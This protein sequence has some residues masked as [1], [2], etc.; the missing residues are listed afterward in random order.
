MINLKNVDFTY[1]NA[2]TNIGVHHVNLEISKGQVVLLCGSSGCG[3]TTLTRMINGLIP[4]FYEGKLSGDI[5]VCGL[6]VKKSELYELTPF[7]GSVFQNPKSQFYTVQ[8]DSEIVFGCENIGLKK[9][10]IYQRFEDVVGKLNISPL[11]G[12]SLFSLSGGQ[13]QKIACAS[14]ATLFPEIFVMDEPSSNLDIETIYELAEIIRE[15][16]KEKKTVVIAEHRLYWLMDIADRVIYIKDGKILQDI[17]I[18]EFKKISIDTLSKMGLR[19]RKISFDNIQFP[20]IKSRDYIYFKDFSFS[21]E[22]EKNVNIKSLMIPCGSVV[23]IIGKN[24]AG[25]STFGRCMCG[26]EKKTKG[27]MI[28]YGKELKWKERIKN[29]Y[30]VMQDVNHQLFTESV[31]D[32]I[33]LSMENS[34]DNESL[35]KV[36]AIEIL[37]ALNLE[38]FQELHP[39]SLSG[40][41]KQRVSV[42]CAL[43]SDKKIL[44]YDE[45]TSGLDYASM[46]DVA[47][48]IRSMQRRGKTQFVITHDP[49]LI[50]KC[51]NYLM[52]MDKGLV[53]EVGTIEGER[54]QRMKEFFI[55]LIDGNLLISPRK[56][57]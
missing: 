29:C 24:G 49:E 27:T 25:K 17:P 34:A 38:E 23:A 31:L 54:L 22:K 18:N 43:A 19:S 28:L 40:G 35:K 15:W 5:T 56:C 45:P 57:L 20:A 21:Y 55:D 3:K 13:K 47:E 33:L 42:A 12:K 51:C 16:K 10:L 8:T 2:K 7:V 30:L 50:E 48:G 9:E 32:E 11:L 53:I 1:N 52:F 39:M 4:N 6:D 14:V 41:Q 37:K 36:K 44:V 26:L 46:L